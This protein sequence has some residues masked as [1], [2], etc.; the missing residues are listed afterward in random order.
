MRPRLP[1]LLEVSVAFAG[2]VALFWIVAGS[3]VF[4]PDVGGPGR[5]PGFAYAL[6][7]VAVPVGLALAGRDFETYGLT[8]SPPGYH[9]RV[10]AVGLLPLVALGST[11]S[12]IAWR[13]WSGSTV[14]SIVAVGVLGLLVTFLPEPPADESANRATSLLIPLAFVGVVAAS[15]GDVATTVAAAYLLVAPAEELFFRGY[16][17]SRLNET[18]GRPFRIADLEWGWGLLGASALFGL[19]HVLGPGG[20]AG[21]PHGLWTFFAGLVFGAV[22]EKSGSVAGPAVLH[23]VLNYGPQAFAFDLLLV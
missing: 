20:S 10:I 15:A 19:W 2:V 4:D 8:V 5:W 3:P 23:G 7:L 11:L 12:S 14:V 13:T 22:R 21:L 17:Q 6:L 18:F 16:V 9:L 1:A